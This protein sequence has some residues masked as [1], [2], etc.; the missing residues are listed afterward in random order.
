MVKSTRKQAAGERPGVVGRIDGVFDGRLEGWAWKPADAGERVALDVMIEGRLAAT[1]VA[2]L[3][4]PDLESGDN[5]GWHGYSIALPAGDFWPDMARIVIKPA[6]GG[7]F[8]IEGGEALWALRSSPDEPVVDVE[9]EVAGLFD[10]TYYLT[11]VGPMRDPLAHYRKTGWRRGLDPHPLFSTRYYLRC[12][13]REVVDDP[14]TDFVT[15]GAA[16]HAEVH[17]LLDVRR[18]LDGRPDVRLGGLHPL[19]HYLA[20]GGREAVNGFRLFDAAA[21]LEQRP[22]VAV[23]DEGALLHYLRAGWREGARP[24]ADFDPLLFSRLADT[25]ADREPL[26][27][28]VDQALAAPRRRSG[29]VGVSVIMLNLGKAV[30]TLQALHVLRANTDMSDVEVILIDNGS[31]AEDFALLAEYG[32]AV[33]LVRSDVNLGFGEANNIGVERARG[34]VAVLLNNDAFVSPGW[35]EALRRLLQ[36]DGVG[37]ASPMFLYPNGVLQEAGADI[38]SD[39]IVHQYGKGLPQPAASNLVRR[40]VR[41]A[42]AAALAIRTD[43]FKAVGGFDPAYD[44]AYYEDVDLCLK[45][46]DAGLT[47]TYDPSSRVVHLENATSSDAALLPDRT[48][49]A[50]L[51]RLAFVER[52]GERLERPTQAASVPAKRSSAFA[53]MPRKSAAIHVGAQLAATDEAQCLLSYASRT[54]EEYEWRVYADRHT[55]AS[56]VRALAAEFGLGG[57]EDATAD[58]WSDHPA[59]PRPDLFLSLSVGLAGAGA[60]IGRRNLLFATGQDR[61]EMGIEAAWGRQAGYDGVIAPSEH[62]LNVHRRLEARYG[63]SPL[64]G[65]VFRPYIPRVVRDEAPRRRRIAGLGAYTEG[66]RSVRHD[67]MIQAFSTLNATLDEPA[68]FH[69]LGLLPPSPEARRYFQ[70]LQA[71]ALAAGVILHHNCGPARFWE[72][73]SQADVVWSLAGLEEDPR[74]RP[75]AYDPFAVASLTA[76]AAGAVPIVLSGGASDELV[77]AGAVT[78][79]SV[80]QL[81]TA[82]RE[83]LSGGPIEAV[84]DDGG[85]TEESRSALSRFLDGGESH[86]SAQ[87]RLEC[88]AAKS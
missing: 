15:T 6:D 33:D 17:P 52:W 30:L 45:L 58:R 77:S 63:L 60:P 86:V 23:S 82:T 65:Q 35:L 37:A 47:A 36:E 46:Q 18:Y 42:S 24:H 53:S 81:L 73:V 76:L 74:L 69:L 34:A 32:G 20:T 11:Q 14:L 72:L 56:R 50:S 87:G 43:A 48:S 27:E 85:S 9:A 71:N 51:N 66:F 26:T 79:A 68:E 57:L 88:V 64:P 55:S 44:P 39:G 19:T 22:D 10:A 31:P 29:D 40:D 49:L 28:L 59:H 38:A 21:Y 62:A 2:D 61:S 25:P 67:V 3:Y 7:F 4:R 5:D 80:T 41:Y 16:Q 78:V 12:L 70:S 1:G 84:R 83:A 13:G 54:A 75:D 8:E